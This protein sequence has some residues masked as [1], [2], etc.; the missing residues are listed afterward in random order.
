MADYYPSRVADR[1]AW[2]ANF[3]AEAV[4]TGTTLGLN[5]AA[6]TQIPIDASTVALVVNY[7]EQAEAFRQEVTAFRDNLLNGD[8]LAPMP[9]SPAMSA[10]PTFDIDALPGIEARTRGYVA[11]IKAS[12]N[13]T[14][15]IGEAYGI[16]PAASELQTPS[17]KG[18]AVP[19]TS[20]VALKIGKGGHPATAID[21]QRN[22][23]GW[24]E[25]GR[26]LTASFTDTTAPLVAGQP[27]QR[28]YRAQ[29]VVGND[30]VGDMS[31]T[32][33]LVTTP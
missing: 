30:R 2:H 4:A 10:A 11:I 18:A 15:A 1:V 21:M 25:I 19:G 16:V 6:V 3:S 8:P 32:V 13:Y 9:V 7:S 14:Q 22:G 17:L 5:A 12:P 24:S 33:T 28:S 29:G 27:E 31:D 20:N 26:P 23:G